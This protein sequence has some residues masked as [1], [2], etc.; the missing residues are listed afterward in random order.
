MAAPRRRP[1]QTREAVIAALRD[2]P[3]VEK[4][5]MSAVGCTSRGTMTRLLRQLRTEGLITRGYV[6]VERG[7]E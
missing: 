1:G 5:L 6:L 4:D 7:A 3:M 2:S